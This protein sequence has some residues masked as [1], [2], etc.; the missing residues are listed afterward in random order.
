MQTNKIHWASLLILVF[1]GLSASF[2]LLAAFGV[3]VN[4]LIV[5]FT[6]EGDAAGQMVSAFTFGFEGVVFLLCCWFVLQKTMGREQADVILKPSFEGW[7]AAAAI[8]LVIM[9]V[10]IGAAVVSTEVAWLA[11]LILP[12]LTITVIVPPIWLY[13]GIGSKGIEFGPRWRVFSIL[14]LGMTLGP[15]LMVLAEIILLVGGIILGAIF[16]A[17]W[18]P[19]LVQEIMTLGAVIQRETDPDAILSLLAP[20]LSNP[21]LIAAAVGYV[22]IVVPLV[23]EMFKP[24][25]VWIFA[26]KIE[27]PAQGFVMGLLSGA[28]FALVESLN[29]SGGGTESWPVIVTVRAGTSLLHIAASGLVGWGIIS[30]FREKRVLRLFAAYFS[31]VLIHGIWNACAVGVGL[32]L[33]GEMIGKPEW[34]YNVMP[35]MA[36]GMFTLAVG[37]FWLLAAS[38]KKIR[39]LPSPY[40][41]PV[42]GKAGDEGVQ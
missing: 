1:L 31:A 12:V 23:E 40:P 6:K 5:L 17:V 21:A 32:S 42:G 15:V 14:G 19:N 7:H 9:S 33:V 39:N 27:S 34:L 38:N 25:A 26:S 30:A 18:Q 37:M 13:F 22:A 20:Y 3:G 41:P 29:A 4:S 16:I 35:A 28:A 2:A 24:L 36:G 10:A 8:G 11:W